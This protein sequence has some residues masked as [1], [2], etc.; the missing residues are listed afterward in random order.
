MIWH[1]KHRVVSHCV[2]CTMR[3]HCNARLKHCT[4]D[5]ESGAINEV[6]VTYSSVKPGRTCTSD[7][8][9]A[10]SHHCAARFRSHDE[11]PSRPSFLQFD[12]VHHT[13]SP[14]HQHRYPLCQYIP[15]ISPIPC[16]IWRMTKPCYSHSVAWRSASRLRQA[17]KMV[18][19]PCQ[20]RAHDHQGCQS[21]IMFSSP[22]SNA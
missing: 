18:R 16:L 6:V 8:S 13:S 14:C 19:K 3:T 1:V 9:T 2:A 22:K 15:K 21:S 17:K 12:R 20:M 10:L 11:A 5:V 7:S 4:T